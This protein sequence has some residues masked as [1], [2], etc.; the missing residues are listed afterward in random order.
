MQGFDEEEI[1]KCLME[2]FK[3]LQASEFHPSP[4]DSQHYFIKEE[5][6]EKDRYWIDDTWGVRFED[7]LTSGILYH[8]EI[9]SELVT[10][11]E[12]ALTAKVGRGIMIKGPHGIGKSH[13]IVNLI[14]KLLYGSEGKYFVTF[15]P[16][17]SRWEDV[18]D[19]YNAI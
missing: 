11:V 15:I 10:E 14:R 7:S 12:S 18:G 16:D 2:N 4:T 5:F 9:V 8:P 13:S 17:C 6:D 3:R 19:L 1:R